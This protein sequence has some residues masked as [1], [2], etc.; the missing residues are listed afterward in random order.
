MNK[1]RISI[2]GATGSIGQNTLDLIARDR[3]SYE[4]VVLTAG[5]NIDL[6]VKAALEF[7][8]QAVVAATNDQFNVLKTA[9]SDT[10]IEVGTGRTALLESAT[11]NCDLA[12]SAIVGAAGLEPGLIALEMELI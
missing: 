11:R 6:L 4:V 5:S 8:P 9:L 2:F 10:Q 3:Q 7:Q 12:F 1:K